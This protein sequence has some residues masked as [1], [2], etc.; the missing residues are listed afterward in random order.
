MSAAPRRVDAAI[1]GTGQA[2]PALAV[3]LAQDGE[4]VAIIEGHLV[5]GSCVNVGCTPTKTLRK[6]ARVAYIAGRAAD[7]GVRVGAV[8][9]DFAA[10]MARTHGRVDAAR[11]GLEDWLAQQERLTLMRGWGRFEGRSDDGRFLLQVG[12]ERLAARRVYL[13]T[14]T[15]AAVPP[16]PGIDGVPCLDNVSALQLKELPAHLLVLGGSYIGLE[17]GQIFRRLGS[18]VTVIEA[19]PR[20]A[21]REDPD[22]SEAIRAMLA[23]E[24]IEIHCGR[25]VDAVEAVAG[26]SG[27][28]LRLGERAIDGSHLLVAIGRTPNTDRLN[29]ESVGVHCDD[30]GYVPTDA[31]LRTNVEGIWA[32]GD[33]N[34]RGAFT[35]TSYHDQEIVLAHH[36]APD[37]AQ[38]D[39]GAGP[40]SAEQRNMAYAMFTDPPLGRVGIGEAEAREKVKKG[41][42]ILMATH[43]MKDVSRAKEEGETT[44]LVKLLVDADSGQFLGAAILGIS[45]DE[46]IQVISNFMASGA[47]YLKLKNALPIHPTVAEFLPTILGKLQPLEPAAD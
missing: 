22:V 24:G 47:S 33:I 8:E 44:G 37:D 1:V 19:A 46:V 39:A 40:R 26:G 15:R 13:N 36:R 28:R 20:V 29:L 41:Q 3:A 30:Q 43:A 6:S 11:A 38:A 14:G 23:D 25:K 17:F 31:Q 16:L 18:R 10:A 7:F 12:D 35:H 42:R 34:R 2:G 45:G 5:G 21:S 32:L 27:I 4:Q 9:V